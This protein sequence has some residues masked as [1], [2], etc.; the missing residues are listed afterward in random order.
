MKLAMLAA[1]TE[2]PYSTRV[3]AAASAPVR[4]GVVLP[5]LGVAD[6]DVPVVE[7]REEGARDLAR[8]RPG[9][10]RREI[11]RAECERDLVGVQERL[12][13]AQVGERREDGHLDRA[14]LVLGVLEGP[15]QLLHERDRLQVVEVHLPVARDER[16]ARRYRHPRTSSPGSFFPSRNSRLAPPPVEM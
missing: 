9:V 3:F 1:F 2:P 6:D 12:H 10:M 16:G 13:G 4:L 15:V 14:V 7:L 8:V 5:P 11:L